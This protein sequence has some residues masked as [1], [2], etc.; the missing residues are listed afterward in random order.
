MDVYTRRAATVTTPARFQQSPSKELL[1]L[2]FFPCEKTTRYIED[3]QKRFREEI[4]RTETKIPV[5]R[6]LS[7]L[8]HYKT[9]TKV[10]QMA[11]NRCMNEIT[12]HNSG[13]NQR[14]SKHTERERERTH[15]KAI[16]K[17]ETK[18]RQLLTT[19][20]FHKDLRLSRADL[21]RMV[22]KTERLQNQY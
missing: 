12:N 21:W 19:R 18:K 20:N 2:V 14:R 1:L 6:F 16:E 5:P 10:T 22:Q 8:F 13:S 9:H 15:T 11:I 17:S 7:C 3:T 4:H